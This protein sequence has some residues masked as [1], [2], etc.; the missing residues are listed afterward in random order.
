[1]TAQSLNYRD[2]KYDV[3]FDQFRHG[4]VWLIFA[5]SFVVYFQ[6]APCD[7]LFFLAFPL[8]LFSGLKITATI[9]PLILLLFIYN[10]SAFISYLPVSEDPEALWFVIPSIYMA[11]SAFFFASYL[12]T[13]TEA[14]FNRIRSGY[15]VGATIASTIGLLHYSNFNGIGT[16]I[17]KMVSAE[18]AWPDRASGFFKDPNVFS[19]YLVLPCAMLIQGFMLGTNKR[20]VLSAMS[21]LIIMAALVLAF[22]RGAW[23][24]ILMSVALIAAL[25]LVL[26][27]S[28]T[29]RLRVL[30]CA[31]VGLALITAMVALIMSQPNMREYFLSRLTLLKSYDKGETGRFGNQLNSIPLLINLPLGFGPYQFAR[32]Y[33]LAPHNTFLN[34]FA[35]CGW[36]GGFAYL[37]LSLCNIVVGARAVFTKSPFQNQSILLFACL[38]A[39]MF[40]GIQIDTEHW[41]HYYWI[42]GMMWGLFAATVIHARRSVAQ[43]TH[44]A[45]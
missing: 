25:T 6:P 33:G 37:T 21:L 28:S 7:L 31:L 38:L 42:I 16:I 4:V 43:N 39:V 15:I 34:A 27:N 32:I 35:S 10:F 2:Y 1:M 22:S 45:G 18:T 23:I 3:W 30:L 12:A 44:D 13:D 29:V 20:P 40:Q 41:R 9:A 17:L 11:V 5:F 24:N 8:F 36:V 14:R 26:S 19:T